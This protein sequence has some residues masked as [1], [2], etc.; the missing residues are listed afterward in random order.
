MPVRVLFR[1]V[2][3][4][5]ARYLAG[6][7]LLVATNLCALAIP[8]V[9]KGTIETLSGRAPAAARA[10]LVGAVWVIGLASLQAVARSASRLLLLG[11]GQRV[12]AAIR[13]DLFEHL[14]TLSPDYYQTH[15][16]G[17]LMSRATNDL[18]N[19]AMLIGFGS[20]SLVNTLLVYAGAL[21]AMLRIDYW[22]TAAALVP[23]P[24]LIAAAKRYNTRVHA[25]SLAV[26][27]QLGH[28]STRVQ[29]NLAGSAV[30][31]AYTMEA[32]EVAAF[33]RDNAEQRA[34]VVRLART[35]GTFSPILGMLGGLG[36]LIVL[37]LGGHAVIDGRI[38]LGAFVAFSSYLAYLAWPT[39][40]LGWVLAIMRR[41][42]A[43]MG[44]ILEVLEARP[45]VVDDPGVPEARPAPSVTEGRVELRSLTFDYG[46]HRAPALRDVSLT[47]PGGLFVAV[48]GPTGSGKSTLVHLLSRLWDPPP[49]TVFIDGAEI[50]SL[51]LAALRRAVA[52]VPQE[53][54]LFS[55]PLGENVRLEA[56]AHRLDWAGRIAGLEADV[57]RLPEGW[58]TVVGERG[59]TLSGGQRQRATLARALLRDPR[60]LVLDD[61][62][63]SV[64]AETEAAI[65]TRLRR[66][67]PGRT[68][69]VA[70]HRLRAARVADHIVVLDAGRLVEQG[71]H[72]ALL[73][74]GGLYA[75]LWRRQQ[76]E[77]QLEAAG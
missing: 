5:R 56:D 6:L 7:G 19:V 28:L 1:Y 3:R 68:T 73:A 31:R 4:Y 76:I 40:A 45:S 10:A 16:T 65:L 64:D 2:A 13:D 54:F 12:E 21:G 42:L 75:R 67:F 55:R 34:R 22:L 25:E 8:W 74:R 20:L 30:V 53:A 69:V 70:T 32:T 44:R 47:I 35:Q 27:E 24:L 15:R 57:A 61:A 72:E 60:I 49:G 50:H 29:E 62:F 46:D 37:W 39:I 9:V 36:G 58:Q 51:P 26:Q 43:A 66:G 14:L 18:Q 33:Q 23:C 77:T 48:V 59:L 38:T 71:T 52:V 63:A 17:D 11:A 41:G